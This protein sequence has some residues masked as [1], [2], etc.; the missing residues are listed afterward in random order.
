[1]YRK[2]FENVNCCMRAHHI[3]MAF[4]DVI[5]DWLDKS[6]WKQILVKANIASFS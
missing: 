4:N 5:T 1:M 3:E 2:E 6:G